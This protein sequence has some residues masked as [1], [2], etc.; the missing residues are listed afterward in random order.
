MRGGVYYVV[1]CFC[2]HSNKLM[3]I[4]SMSNQIV[5]KVILFLVALIFA[6][7]VKV[8]FFERSLIF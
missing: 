1:E 3:T 7:V 6:I 5:V 8:L 4:C 2:V